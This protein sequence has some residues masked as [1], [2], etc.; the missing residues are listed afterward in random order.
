MVRACVCRNMQ[1]EPS[2]A[3][4]ILS[5]CECT[6]QRLVCVRKRAEAGKRLSVAVAQG[7]GGGSLDQGG[8]GKRVSS[9]V[10]LTHVLGDFKASG[11]RMAGMHHFSPK[12]TIA[13]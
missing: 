11:S 3:G 2:S 12:K 1:A 5:V 10:S 7:M 9:E 6:S 8:G 13:M 4:C